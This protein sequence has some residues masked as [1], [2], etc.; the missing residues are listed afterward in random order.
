[1]WWEPEECKFRVRVPEVSCGT[2][3]VEEDGL[4]RDTYQVWW[5]F[6]YNDEKDGSVRHRLSCLAC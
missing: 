5:D 6:E 4:I 2:V 1:M 3:V